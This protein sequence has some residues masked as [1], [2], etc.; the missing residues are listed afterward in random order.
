[1]TKRLIRVAKD[2]NVRISVLVEHLQKQGF[3]IENSPR[4]KVTDEAYEVLLRDFE[5]SIIIKSQAD[6][7]T[8]GSRIKKNE[9]EKREEQERERKKRAEEEHLLKELERLKKEE[10]RIQREKEKAA[11]KEQ[12]RLRKILE[13]KGIK[14]KGEID[15]NRFKK[16][17][18]KRL[19]NNKTDKTAQ[20]NVGNQRK[21]RRDVREMPKTE[22]AAVDIKN[23]INHNIYNALQQEKKI[24]Q[25]FIGSIPFQWNYTIAHYTAELTEAVDFTLFDKVICGILQ[26]DE[27]ASLEKIGTILGMNVVDNPDQKQYLDPAEKEILIEALQLLEEYEMITTG[28]TYYSRC[29]LT[30][31]G[32]EYAK[33][34]R[35]FKVTENVPFQLYFDTLSDQHQSAKQRFQNITGN[36]SNIKPDFDLLE[37]NL[38]RTVAAVQ[39][40]NIYN[41]NPE[42]LRSFRD[43]ILDKQKTQSFSIELHVCLVA[44]VETQ[45]YDLKVYIPELDK[46]DANFSNALNEMPEF[47]EVLMLQLTQQFH[48]PYAVESAVLEHQNYLIKRQKEVNILLENKEVEQAQSVVKAT[49]SESN[50]IDKTY[51]INHLKTFITKDYQEIWLVFDELDKT[52]LANLTKLVE[53]FDLSIE[54]SL[55][56]VVPNEINIKSDI[57][58]VWILNSDEIEVT[59][60]FFK[61]ADD[62]KTYI[63]E[64]YPIRI[65]IDATETTVNHVVYGKKDIDVN[66]EADYYNYRNQVI[67]NCLSDKVK[68]LTELCKN[69]EKQK[70]TKQTILEFQQLNQAFSFIDKQER[71][72]SIKSFKE[73][74]ATQLYKL[75]RQLRKSVLQE[76]NT[77]NQ[78][79]SETEFKELK[80]F[81]PIYQQ[82]ENV[83]SNLYADD[84]KSNNLFKSVKELV[85]QKEQALK[86][87]L[88]KKTYIID[89]NVFVEEPNILDWI[90][91]NNYAVVSGKVVDELDNLK[92][93]S[94]LRS[95]V[96]RAIR[97]IKIAQ[98]KKQ[99][100]NNF[101][102]KSLLPD[103]FD[104]R[105]ADNLILS[106]AIMYQNQKNINP[107]LLTSDNAFQVK[108][109]MLNIRTIDLETFLKENPKETGK[110]E[111]QQR[112]PENRNQENRQNRNQGNRKRRKPKNQQT[113]ERREQNNNQRRRKKRRKPKK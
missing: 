48:F 29:R 111:Q 51:F 93:K 112:K 11:A 33:Q 92:K 81:E 61:K 75:K 96:N 59:Q 101:G 60:F 23:N 62:F 72:S 82:L 44:D 104:G 30:A 7:L 98:N 21:S 85:Q 94:E 106:V 64:D 110:K 41:P 39:A 6:Y 80:A 24:T 108:A 56:I 2:L 57:P 109:N 97:S 53:G 87:E 77:L 95:N 74:H 52:I 50:F 54:T 79:L 19:D 3:E 88:V 38:M 5:K 34:G 35:K 28:D 76:L 13:L 83:K 55:F 46:F 73:V 78:Q 58:N 84:E 10:A 8:I 71:Y 37:D 65:L 31:T 70:V 12:E 20:S 32:K 105:S 91:G 22:K 15:S 89:T 25:F 40:P 67:E 14:I 36:R 63:T 100:K 42:Q 66:L 90:I 107:V 47:K 113:N 18:K 45:D 27:V 103:G 17:R 69:S 4:A 102:D 1:M 43:A 16:P 86:D 68:L 99:I 9:V 26:I 49:Y